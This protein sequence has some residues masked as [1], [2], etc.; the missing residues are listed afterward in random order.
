VLDGRQVHHRHLII[1]IPAGTVQGLF[2]ATVSSL[3]QNIRKMGVR[4]GMVFTIIIII[5]II[6]VIVMLSRT[7]GARRGRF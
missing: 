6:I 4:M 5:I 2:P 7:D 3:T 1:G